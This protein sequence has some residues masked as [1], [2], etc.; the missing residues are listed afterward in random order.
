MDNP[1][2]RYTD[3]NNVVRL[4]VILM[5][6]LLCLIGA[7]CALQSAGFRNFTKHDGIIHGSSSGNFSW[8]F[9]LVSFVGVF[10]FLCF[11]PF[12]ISSI[13]LSFAV[14]AFAISQYCYFAFYALAIARMAGHKAQFASMAKAVSPRPVL[15]KLQKRLNLFAMRASFCLNGLRHG[16]SFPKTVFRAIGGHKPVCGLFNSISSRQQCQVFCGGIS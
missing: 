2:T 9:V 16:F 11:C 14:P 8:P 5:V 13:M 6:V 4:Q 12:S 15:V 1:M 7:V 3:R 10:A